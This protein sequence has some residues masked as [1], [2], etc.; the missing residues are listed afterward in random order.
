MV[1]AIFDGARVPATG[2]EWAW[3]VG[4]GA[5]AAGI[6][7]ARCPTMFRTPWAEDGTIFLAQAI[8]KGAVHSLGTAYQGY[9]HT[10]PRLA[11]GL[12]AHLPLRAAPIVIAI[13]VLIVVGVTA[14]VAEAVSGRFIARRPLRVA[15]GLAVGLVPVL[16]AEGIGSAAN[17]QF[18]GLYLVFWLLLVEPQ[19]AS[20]SVAIAFAVVMVVAST[21]VTIVLVP[22]AVA[23]LVTVR[24]D[25]GASRTGAVALLA[26]VLL[27]GLYVVI[28]RPARTIKARGSVGWRTGQSIVGFVNEVFGNLVPHSPGG[29][30]TAANDRTGTPLTVLLALIAAAAIV[31]LVVYMVVRGRSDRWRVQRSFVA[32]C[33]ATLLVVWIVLTVLQGNA[34]PRYAVFPALLGVAALAAL[35]DAA[36]DLVADSSIPRNAR[37]AV[38]VSA[39]VVAGLTLAAVLVGWT[40][41]PYR[42]RAPNWSAQIDAARTHCR[43][44]ARNATLAVAPLRFGSV[45]VGCSDLGS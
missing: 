29:R 45:V 34:V 38:G 20:T 6:T 42:T 2:R 36:L 3:A 13:F 24:R 18:V 39:G 4:T 12:A 15:C 9:L 33:A 43:A 30:L 17:L 25:R 5:G 19:R 16:G 1:R 44:G 21:P 32:W 14:A 40:P 37:T 23:R 41:L 26:S 11:A 35:L 10:M 8:H 22:L 7:A 27:L 28:A 31:T